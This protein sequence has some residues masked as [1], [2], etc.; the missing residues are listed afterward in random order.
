MLMI[1]HIY[2]VQFSIPL[3]LTDSYAGKFDRNQIIVHVLRKFP[4]PRTV[5]MRLRNL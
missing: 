1:K 5:Q 2:P 3:N 4:E